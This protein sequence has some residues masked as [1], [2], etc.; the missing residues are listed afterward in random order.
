MIDQLPQEY[1]NAT[2][3]SRLKA[4]ARTYDIPSLDLLSPFSQSFDSFGSLFIEWDGH[5]NARAYKITASQIKEYLLGNGIIL[6]HNNA[7]QSKGRSERS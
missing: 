2:Y 7:Q 1:P 3:Q 6:N 5:P 4:I